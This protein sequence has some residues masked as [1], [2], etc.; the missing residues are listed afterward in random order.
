MIVLLAINIMRYFNQGVFLTY[1]DYSNMLHPS[2]LSMYLIFNILIIVFLFINKKEK[3]IYLIISAIISI[4][5]LFIAESKAGQLTSLFVIIYISF[6]LI[7]HNYRK[8][9]IISSFLLILVFG[10]IAK[11][12]KRF[13]FFIEAIEH[14]SQIKE[15][16]EAIKESTALRILAWSASV[17]VIKRNP[18]FGVGN[19]DIK[20]ELSNVYAKRNYKMPLEMHMN[21][22]NQYLETYIGQGLIGLIILLIMLLSPLV[23]FRQQA[24]IFHG[25]ILIVALNLV[26][27]SMF[28]TQ[29][30]VIFIVFIYS[31]LIMFFN[32]HNS[33]EVFD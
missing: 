28:N 3:G 15:H 30:G 29:A 22:H 5:T 27:E 11:G 16:P 13:S 21:S 4:F 31:V 14:Y 19:G 23:A 1:N 20:D 10:F 17:D 25:F 24:I 32:S 8:I 7:P 33:K 12:T 9:T 6:Q 18:V 2:Y 26:V